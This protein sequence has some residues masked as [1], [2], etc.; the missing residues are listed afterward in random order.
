MSDFLMELNR[1]ATGESMAAML[2]ERPGLADRPIDTFVWSWGALVIQ[3]SSI[4]GMVPV[5][6][7][8][9][10]VFVVGRPQFINETAGTGD[11]WLTRRI[12]DA[13]PDGDLAEVFDR[14]SGAYVV[15]IADERGVCVLTDPMGVCAVYVGRAPSAGPR[16]I[17]TYIDGVAKVAGRFEHTDPVSLAEML[18]YNHVTFPFTTREGVFELDPASV[19]DLSVDRSEPD[20]DS[21]CLWEPVEPDRFSSEAEL[22]DELVAALHQSGRDIVEGV[23]RPA[24]T[25]SGGRDSRAM[26]AALPEGVC[27]G[28]ITYMTRENRETDVAGRVAAA[29]GVPQVFARRDDNFYPNLMP[30]TVRLIGSDLRGDGHGLCVLDNGLHHRFDLVLGGQLSDTYLKDHYM[31]WS[32]RERHSKVAW[33]TRARAAARKCLVSVGLKQPKHR[34]DVIGESLAALSPDLREAVLERRRERL[35]T[36]ARIRPNSAEEWMRFWPTSR[37]D[38]TSHIQGNLRVVGGDTFY[39]HRHIIEAARKIPPHL[40][41]G[42]R[43]ANAAFAA[44]YGKLGEI[45]NANTGVAANASES[46][47]Q[48][49]CES[50]ARS[51]IARKIE[52]TAAPWNDVQSSWYDAE[53]MQRESDVWRSIRESVLDAPEMDILRGVLADDPRT[54]AQAYRPELR[55]QFNSMVVQLVWHMQNIAAQSAHASTE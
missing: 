29:A 3:R 53:L 38:D 34:R 8:D 40:R 2:A 51:A 1:G 43:L 41:Y 18:V 11:D 14:L 55:P 49:A 37:Q 10:V 52:P 28:A 30:R 26:L 6:E 17:G 24:V 16:A 32:E 33:V 13:C 45:V 19:S 31:P 48:R 21:R 47:E 50:D 39:T 7:G 27:S 54:F 20:V 22:T 35:A 42:G 23:A 5:R 9:R 46:A 44:V 25:L 36:I 4:R 15:G 12:V